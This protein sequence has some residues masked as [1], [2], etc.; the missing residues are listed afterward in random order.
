MLFAN[1]DR[2]ALL[3][4]THLPLA[5]LANRKIY[6]MWSKNHIKANPMIKGTSKKDQEHGGKDRLTHND[7]ALVHS[8]AKGLEC[9]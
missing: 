2:I 1:T 4:P 8:K 6:L 9:P 3:P 7:K 5:F